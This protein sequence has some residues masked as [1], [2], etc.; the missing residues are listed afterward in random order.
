MFEFSIGAFNS[1]FFKD[2]K[3]LEHVKQFLS[4]LFKILKK[5]S[6]LLAGVSGLDK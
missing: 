6:F 2:P 3:I 5:Y 4:C 1:A